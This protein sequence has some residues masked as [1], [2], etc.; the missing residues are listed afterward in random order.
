[1]SYNITARWETLSWSIQNTLEKS[2][3]H[4]IT[5]LSSQPTL[6]ILEEANP[7]HNKRRHHLQVCVHKT[8]ATQSIL[9]RNLFEEKRRPHDASII[10]NSEERGRI[11]QEQNKGSYLDRQRRAKQATKVVFMGMFNG[12]QSPPYSFL[13]MSKILDGYQYFSFKMMEN[14]SLLFLAMLVN[15]PAGK[16]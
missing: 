16:C 6:H 1:M 4:N 12:G 8:S 11:W 2:T 14:S 13:A 7:N 3:T 5:D 9:Q 10:S 15:S